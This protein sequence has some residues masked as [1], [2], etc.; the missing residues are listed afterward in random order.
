MELVVQNTG[1][2]LTPAGQLL[3]SRSESI[4]REM[5]NM[6]NEI[7]GM[8]SEAVVE[9]IWFSFIDWFYFY[10]R[11]DQQVQRGV[12]ESAGFYV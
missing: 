9:V 10:V 12:P 2:T 11:D 8:S 6:V 5:K 4:T 3:L 7:S 1:V